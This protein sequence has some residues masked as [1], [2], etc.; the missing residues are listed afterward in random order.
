MTK[1]N[2]SAP[3]FLVALLIGTSVSAAPVAAEESDDR[4]RK[5]RVVLGPQL[6]PSYPGSDQV[7]FSPL[8]DLTRGREGEDFVFVAP[9]E[10]FGF[11]LF[12]QNGFSIGPSLGFEGKRSLNDVNGTLP[13]VDFTVEVGGFVQ[14]Q[15]SESFR[16]RAEVRQAV[17]GHDGLIG[18][19]SA[20]YIIRDGDEQL[21]SIG[22]RLTLTDQNYQESYFSVL[23]SQVATSGLPAY[24]SDGG[25]QAVG[26]TI[27]YLRQLSTH[28]GIYSYVNYE[29]LVR[30]PSDSPVVRQFGSRDQYSGGLALTYTFG[31]GVR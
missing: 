22:P 23:P 13:E 11:S 5:T 17:N 1:K 2:S 14:Y 15:S 18:V 20:D 7:S 27:G 29:R 19:L 30:D 31:P 8:V 24:D 26:G 9:D 25:L 3:H 12:E 21:L 4:A 6:K 28:W 16:L 10:S